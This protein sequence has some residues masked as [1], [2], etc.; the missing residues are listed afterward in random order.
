MTRAKRRGRGA[1]RTKTARARR[2]NAHNPGVIHVLAVDAEAPRP[3]AVPPSI[4]V[5]WAHGPEDAAEKLARNRRIDAVLF[6]DDRIAKATAEAVKADGGTPPPLFRAG[7]TSVAGIESLDPD[8]L[9]DD[10][11]RKL[12]E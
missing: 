11:R 10:L 9:F 2:G 7:A 12:G 5:L 1:R 8:D 6:F 3:L 4:E